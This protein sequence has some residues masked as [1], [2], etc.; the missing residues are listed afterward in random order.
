MLIATDRPFPGVLPPG[1]GPLLLLESA[2]GMLVVKFVDPTP[3]EIRDVNRGGMEF[4]LFVDR[5]ADEAPLPFLLVR[6]EGQNWLEMPYNLHL[7]ERETWPRLDRPLEPDAGLNMLAF[8]VDERTRRVVSPL[9]WF[10]LPNS[11]TAALWETLR[12]QAELPLSRERQV[13]R[14]RDVYRRFPTPE[15]MSLAGEAR[16]VMPSPQVE[17]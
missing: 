6:F 15:A 8:V 12:R 1:E 17:E 13:E 7:Q 2:G 9:R 11:V 16:A 14:V 4:V 3:D 10:T 5:K